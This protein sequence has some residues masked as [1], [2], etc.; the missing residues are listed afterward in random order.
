MKSRTFKNILAACALACATM[1]QLPFAARAQSGAGGAAQA[2]GGSVSINN[3]AGRVQ[4]RLERGSKV[5]VSNR[6]GRITVT[7]WDKDTVEAVAVSSKGVPEAVQLEMTADPQQSRSTVSLAVVG[8]SRQPTLFTPS[9]AMSAAQMDMLRKAETMTAERMR[10]YERQVERKV[11]DKMKAKEKAD[12]DKNRSETPE[13]GVVIVQPPSVTVTTPGVTVTAPG[14]AIAPAQPRG[15]QPPPQPRPAP[16]PRPGATVWGA[17]R[18]A[19][20][21]HLDVKVP[22]YAELATISVGSGDFNVSNLDGPVT[23]ETRGGNVT[24]SRVGALTVRSRGGDVSVDGVEGMVYVVAN[25]GDITVRNAASEVRATTNNGDINV[26]CARG[27]VDVSTA[28]GKIGLSNIGGDVDAVTT[29]SDINYTGA[30]TDGGR[31]RLKSMEGRV[32]MSIPDNSPGFTANLMSYN[33]EAASEFAVRNST[34]NPSGKGLR[35]VESNH[36][37][38]RAVILLDS[39]GQTVQLTKLATT[40]ATTCR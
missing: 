37:S 8:R 40:A 11:E 1:L 26:A 38:G 19:D 30:I 34:P 23:V 17:A 33:R 12:K 7:G 2:S 14:V 9:A 28:H 13:G 27:R 25:S 22:R 39:F 31:Y 32:I 15:A 24:A 35:R 6:Y 10:E 29:N 36:G 5:A 21:I 20:E 16:A 4:I 3:Q 18:S